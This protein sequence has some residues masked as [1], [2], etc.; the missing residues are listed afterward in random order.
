MADTYTLISSVT[1]G[2]GGASSIDFT[3]IPATYTDLQLV[4]S[5]R[6]NRA[7]S[8]FDYV[9]IRLN[10]DSSSTYTNKNLYGNSTNAYSGS[11]SATYIYAILADGNNAT[12]NTFSNTSIY[13][14][15]YAGSA[16]K[17]ISIDSVTENNNGSADA[18]FANLTAGLYPSTSAIN[19]I[20][21]GPFNGTGWLQYSTAYLYGIK[22]S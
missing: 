12:T 19:A 8:T 13:I 20:Q 7:A 15:N 10:A 9:F 21:V 4:L 11:S 3:S 14:P 16:Q 17:S 6:S 1:V 2:A 18:A 22:N 5:L